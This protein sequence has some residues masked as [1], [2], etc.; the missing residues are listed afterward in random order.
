MRNVR[1]FARSQNG[2]SLIEILIGIG[3][4]S[5]FAASVYTTVQF[6]FKITY[7]S[8]IRIIETAI[9]N[10]EIER[11]RNFAFTEIGI[12]GGIPAGS[13][14]R[15]VTTTRSNL[16]FTITRTVRNIDDPFDGTIGGTP[17]DISPADYKFLEV[18]VNCD[19]CR[20]TSPVT[21]HTIIAPKYLEG[22]Q[23]TGALFIQVFDASAAP[24]VNATVHVVGSTVSP[25]VDLS[26]T[27]DTDGM[28]RIIGLPAGYQAY[29]VTVTKDGYT[30]D[31]TVTSTVSVPN[32]QKLPIT[33][34]SQAVTEVSFSIDRI[35]SMALTMMDA[36]CHAIGTASAHLKGTKLLGTEPDVYMVDETVAAS[37][38]GIYDWPELIWDNYTLT[39]SG[40]DLMGSIP[41]IPITLQPGDAKPVS[42]ILGANTARSLLVHVRDATNQQPLSDATVTVSTTVFNQVNTTGVGHK[43]Q[44]DWSGGDGQTAYTNETKYWVHDGGID[45]STVPGTIQLASVAGAYVAS[46]VLES[47]VIDMGAG[48]NVI[49]LSWEPLSQN[50]ALGEGAV[51]FQIAASN[52]AAPASWSYVGYDGTDATYY[53]A[54]HLALHDSHDGKRYLRYKLFLH[55]ND[56]QVTPLVSDV[57]IRYT[58]TCTPPGQAYIPNVPAGTV[59]LTV[60]RSG[61]QTKYQ[62]VPIAGE[63][64][65]VIDLVSQ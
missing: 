5:L 8:R 31:R 10:E 4:F 12:I 35:S 22:T 53:D 7:Q 9:G 6:V 25:A 34:L 33:I 38:S 27:T 40:Y 32:P 64:T 26:D 23:T 18:S 56:T 15:T 65:A 37:E 20:Q 61:Y 51:R 30:E 59:G 16:E 21:M 43:R 39:V 29:S 2:F 49:D 47:S 52:E 46:G 54:T 36:S 55:T 44:T 50:P 17:A 57:M 11:L 13:L 63:T 62:E 14:A 41:G 3:V 60:A 45:A 24:V 19:V 58:S 48:V 28:L 1:L 42:L